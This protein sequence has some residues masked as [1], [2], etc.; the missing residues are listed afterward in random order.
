MRTLTL[1]SKGLKVDFL[2]FNIQST[3][4]K[5]ILLDQSSKKQEVLTQ[6]NKYFY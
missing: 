3:N 2:S 4:G 5:S 1:N 6:P